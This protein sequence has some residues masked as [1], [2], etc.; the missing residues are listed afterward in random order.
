MSLA[1][2]TGSEVEALMDALL[3]AFPTLAELRELV[4]VEYEKNVDAITDG[5]LRERVFGLIR[6]AEA[7]GWIAELVE[8]AHRKN[9]ENPALRRFLDAHGLPVQPSPSE[10]APP[11]ESLR[12]PARGR[13]KKKPAPGRVVSASGRGVAAGGDMN[14]SIV[15]TGD[16]NVV[17]L[18]GKTKK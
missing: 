18:G 12:A 9:P 10:A 7:E 4:R 1:K 17:K 2:L 5:S 16:G 3:S 14:G 15:I 13:A 6:K 11:D 8:G